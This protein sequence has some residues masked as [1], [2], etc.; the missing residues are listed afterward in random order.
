MWRSAR[1]WQHGP[2]PS[3]TTQERQWRTRPT[4][5]DGVWAAEIDPL[6]CS[7]PAGK[8]KATTIIECPSASSG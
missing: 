1:K 7:D 3:E 2:L 6:L 8:L 5:F 4:P